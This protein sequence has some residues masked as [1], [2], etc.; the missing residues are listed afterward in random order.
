[1]NRITLSPRIRITPFHDRVVAAGCT[2]ISVYNKMVM[3]TSYGD[4]KAEYDRIVNAVSIWDVSVERQ[5][6]ISGPD[7]DACVQYLTARDLSKMQV[8]QGY[9][10]AMCDHAGER[11]PACQSS[12]AF[13]L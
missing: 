11:G 7:S 4:L 1:M 9:Y 3:P 2:D 6:E 12:A 13:S 5:V 10:V 8:G